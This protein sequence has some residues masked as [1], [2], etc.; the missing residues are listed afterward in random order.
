MGTKILFD[1]ANKSYNT[2]LLLA[3]IFLFLIGVAQILMERR[4]IG[5]IGI[6]RIGYMLALRPLLGRF[7]LE[8]GHTSTAR[9]QKRRC[10]LERTK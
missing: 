10:K 5:Q 1:I 9:M 3:P 8:A 7:S 2:S 4:K 6:K